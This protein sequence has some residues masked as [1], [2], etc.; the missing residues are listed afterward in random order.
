MDWLVF[1]ISILV[2]ID[3]LFLIWGI[4]LSVRLS[5]LDNREKADF[6][7]LTLMDEIK[8]YH[9]KETKKKESKKKGDK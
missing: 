9:K 5:R 6:V 8:K 2:A 3:V 4:V 1:N 7:I